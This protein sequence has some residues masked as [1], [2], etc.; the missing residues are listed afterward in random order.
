MGD[1]VT[2]GSGGTLTPEE[3][4]KRREEEYDKQTEEMM[5]LVIESTEKFAEMA[6]D[7]EFEWVGAVGR[8]KDG[9]K[10]QFLHVPNKSKD[11]AD[12]KVSLEVLSFEVAMQYNMVEQYAHDDFEGSEEG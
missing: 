8:A 11:L 3:E 4:E 10:Y 6:R 12:T 1:V 5:R 2:L 7:E 9:T